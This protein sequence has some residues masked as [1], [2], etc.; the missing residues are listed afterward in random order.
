MSPSPATGSGTHT[1]FGSKLASLYDET[2]SLVYF[3]AL[4]TSQGVS[5]HDINMYLYSCATA[6]TAF[7]TLNETL[8][9]DANKGTDPNGAEPRDYLGIDLTKIEFDAPANNRIL[10]AAS[11][12]KYDSTNK[13]AVVV[14]YWNTFTLADAGQL[15]PFHDLT[16]P[17]TTGW[18]SDVSIIETSNNGTVSQGYVAVGRAETE[19]SGLAKGGS[20]S[21]YEVYLKATSFDL[22]SGEIWNNAVVSLGPSSAISINDWGQHVSLNF[23]SLSEEL[24]L[25]VAQPFWS[26]NIKATALNLGAIEVQTFKKKSDTNGFDTFFPTGTLRNFIDPTYDNQAIMN[27]R[28]GSSMNT[29]LVNHELLIAA[30]SP[31]YSASLSAGGISHVL[32]SSGSTQDY[33]QH[34]KLYGFPVDG[35]YDPAYCAY[36]PPGFYG[37]ATARISFSSSTPGPVTL[38][39]IFKDAHIENIVELEPSRQRILTGSAVT[40]LTT[41]Q[42]SSKMNISSSIALFERVI[43]PGVEFNISEDGAVTTANKAVPSTKDAVR[44]AIS[45]KYECPVINLSSSE[46]SQNYTSF[47]PIISASFLELNTGTIS[48]E[49]PQSTWTSYSNETTT[50]RYNFTLKESFNKNDVVTAQTGSLIDLCGFTSGVKNIGTVAD[51][52]TITE[53]IMVIPYTERAILKKT[54]EIEKGKHFFRLNASELKRQ[55]KSIEDNGFAVSEDIRETSI[56]ELLSAMK[57]YVIPPHYNFLSYKDIKPFAAYFLEFEHTLTQKDLSDIWQGVTPSISV[58]PQTEEVEI[59]HDLDKHNMLHNIDIPND[60]KFM[61]FKVKKKAEWNY[62]NITTDSTDDDRFRFDF[63]GNGKVE[64]VPEYSY[65][66]PYDYFSLV[67]RAKVAVDF[68]FK[69]PEEDE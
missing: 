29:D 1:G 60:I 14:N 54:V 36:T 66:W 13:G 33:K 6:G 2:D 30:G 5:T 3:A 50:N 19:G 34:G 64:V 24:L 44:W 4:D 40:S 17:T 47:D 41:L 63:Q 65:N 51:N 20:V 52:R 31:E 55:N 57:S 16:A 8:F 48:Y 62:Y 46:Y 12:Q 27:P 28:F 53:A 49:P 68:T 10:F 39:E 59:S 38:E 45:T 69:K 9:V 35:T 56:S 43:N 32:Y 22:S 26:K 61:V 37:E 15:G 42:D 58:N 18:G 21:L 11:S 7:T 25:S 67:E 23:D